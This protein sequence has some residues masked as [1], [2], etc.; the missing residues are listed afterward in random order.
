MSNSTGR[1]NMIFTP[2]TLKGAYIIELEK[3]EDSRGFFARTWDEKEFEAHG[4][5][6]KP[7]QKNMSYSTKKG[8][9]R[10]MHYQISPYEES[11]LIRCTKGAIYDVIIDLR[12][13]SPTFKQ[14]FGVELNDTNYKMLFLSEGFAHGFITLTDTTEVSYQVS[15]F[16]TPG[17][18]QIIRYNDPQFSIP[19]PMEV[20]EITDKDKNQADYTG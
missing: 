2:T 15:A 1:N 13:D 3:R 14:W 4:I 9:M 16:Y 5:F 17:S 7:V 6:R 19:W 20:T 8:T 12:K 18:E 10:G 11:K